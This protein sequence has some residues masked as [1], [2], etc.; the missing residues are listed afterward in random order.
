MQQALEEVGA[1]LVA[2]GE[3][4]AAQQPGQGPFHLPAV[5]AQPL[6]GLDPTTGDPRADAS[7]AQRPSASGEVIALV[8]V[9]L[10]R[11]PARP[12]R[13]APRPDHRWDGIHQLFQERRVVGVGG[14]QRDRERRALPID[15]QVILGAWLASVDRIRAGQLP[16]CRA[17][18]LTAS[19][20][21][22]DQSS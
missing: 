20:D 16:P 6:A 19:T 9:Q 12:T 13:S 11:A 1:A 8:S 2:D 10:G 4:A 5:A 15:Q 18:M 14:R 22:R 21:A 17:R 7:A 3:P